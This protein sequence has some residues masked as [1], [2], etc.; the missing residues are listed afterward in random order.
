[1]N[2]ILI[3]F[4]SKSCKQEQ[5]NGCSNKWNGLGFE[6]I[7]TCDCHKKMMLDESCSLSNT[8]NSPSCRNGEYNV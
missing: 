2:T 4:K 1:M 3:D 7:C 8:K 5:H 6:V